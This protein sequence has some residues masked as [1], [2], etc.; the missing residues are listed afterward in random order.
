MDSSKYP[1]PVSYTGGTPLKRILI[2]TDSRGQ[3][4]P[5]GQTHEIFTE[6]LAKHP[7]LDV[8]LFLCPMKWTTTLDFLEQFPPE[9][10][11]SYDHV[12]LYT[13]I[14]DWSP[15]SASSARADLYDNK[16][17]QNIEN[18]HLNT[19]IYSKKIVNNKKKIFDRV[20][21]ADAMSVHLSRPYETQYEGQPTL[22]MYSLDMA[23]DSLIPL[24]SHIPGLIFINSNR[25]VRGW[26]GDF[27]RGRP[28]NIA[29]TEKYSE[30]FRDQ[31]VAAG[32]DVIDLLE[33]DTEMV[34]SHTC[35]NLHLS[36]TG[37]DYIYDRIS[38]LIFKQHE[39]P[40]VSIIVP[41]YNVEAWLRMALDSLKFQSFRDFEA[42]I[43]DDSSTDRSADIARSFCDLD[44]RFRYMRQENRGLGGARNTGIA[45]SRGRYI[46]FFDSDD[47]LDPEYLKHAVATARSSDADIVNGAYARIDERNQ[48]VGTKELEAVLTDPNPDDAPPIGQRVLALRASSMSCARLYRADFVR[49]TGLKFPDGLPHEDWFFTYKLL[50][51]ARKVV[52]CKHMIYLWRVREGSLSRTTTRGHIDSMLKLIGD[53]DQF[54]SSLPRDSTL[55]SAAD[56]RT[57]I[58]FAQLLNR[59]KRSDAEVLNY[60]FSSASRHLNII[61]GAYSRID[62]E[63]MDH[64][65]RLQAGRA[66]EEV[67]AYAAIE[68]LSKKETYRRVR[69]IDQNAEREMLNLRGAFAGER[70]FIIGNGPSLNKCDI[71]LL[72]NEFTFAVNSFFYKTRDEGFI[73]TFFVVE[74]NKVMEDNVQ[75][76]QAYPAPFR[77]FPKE[78]ARY[79]LASPDTRFFTLN[80]DFYMK[81]KPYYCIPRFS[82]EAHKEIFAGQTVTYV[83]LQLAFYM[84]FSEVFL[85]GMDFDYVIPKEHI[86]EGNHILSTTDDPN[87]FHKDYF[88]AG[89][90]WK[91][92]KLDRVLM[93][94]R[95]ADLAYSSVGRKIYNATIGGKLEIFDRVDY[96]ALLRD[97]A[98]GRKRERPIPPTV[99]ARGSLDRQH[100]HRIDIPAA[101]VIAP[102]AASASPTLSTQLLLDPASTLPQIESGGALQAAAEALLRQ[103]GPEAEH[104][105]RVRDWARRQHG[106]G[107]DA[108]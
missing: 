63:V 19:V 31:L 24:L 23:R 73:P 84:G 108:R 39:S 74:D 40:E 77:F 17:V 61:A 48:P 51:L 36:R 47:L 21:G 105:A 14:V 18:F 30:L 88:G 52:K 44:S 33:W 29:L 72:G 26:D 107:A 106:R 34:R 25:F 90:T 55:Q 68:E 76:I 67:A 97:P 71:G 20:F 79:N 13:G 45:S 69:R 86:R 54:L 32:K 37:S 78:Y 75:D 66:I 57:L 101:P 15:R 27:K 83:N 85:I 100:G 93:N 42:V 38:K 102:R 8:D 5:A 2:F 41:V 56:Q 92:P 95:M 80:Q 46:T 11:A 10:L 3:H 4:K 1:Q 28:E 35:D 64:E 99:T 91:D 22:N 6:R 94:Y 53:T 7:R 43:V 87:H 49:S 50:L 104:F 62:R 65:Q 96:E 103:G 70:C 98:T 16:N 59:S 58:L 82:V 81:S 9:R 12:I 60:F 89:K